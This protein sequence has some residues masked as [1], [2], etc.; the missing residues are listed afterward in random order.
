MSVQ[1]YINLTEEPHKDFIFR[2][3]RSCTGDDLSNCNEGRSLMSLNP[4]IYGNGHGWLDA[5]ATFYGGDMLGRGTYRRR[6]R[7]PH[8]CS[9]HCP[10]LLWPELPG[11]IGDQVH[12]PARVVHTEL[13]CSYTHRFQSSQRGSTQRRQRMVQPSTPAVRPLSARFSAHRAGAMSEAGRHKVH[14]HSYF[15]LVLITNV[16]S[17]AHV[18][19]VSI[20]SD[21]KGDCRTVISD[22]VVCSFGQ[23]FTGQKF[24]DQGEVFTVA[25]RV[26]LSVHGAAPAGG[27]GGGGGGVAALESGAWGSCSE[28]VVPRGRSCCSMSPLREATGESW[29]M[30]ARF[31]GSDLF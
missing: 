15:T 18:T 11:M 19:A 13:G 9:E 30:K 5:H 4:C 17:A 1:H 2:S 24:Q 6:L 16:G 7:K 31:C 25:T 23:T 29:A 10:V 12:R 3:S 28:S 26:F 21:K 20:K 27:G 22:E 14:R 8:R